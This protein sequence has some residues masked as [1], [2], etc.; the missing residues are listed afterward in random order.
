MLERV[1]TL[2]ESEGAA[3]VES[4]ED[5]L[6]EAVD[7]IQD[8][9]KTLKS[10]VLSNPDEF[11]GETVEDTSKNIRVFAEVATAQYVHEISSLCGTLISQETPIQESE[12]DTNTPPSDIMSEYI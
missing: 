11:I 4:H 12:E 1:T 5:M 3:L 7:L 6:V 9:S 10:F 8:F 2:L